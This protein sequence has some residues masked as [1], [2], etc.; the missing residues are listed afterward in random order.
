MSANWKSRK[1]RQINQ[2]KYSNLIPITND[3]TK[4]KSWTTSWTTVVCEGDQKHLPIRTTRTME[5]KKANEDQ[6]DDEDLVALFHQVSITKMM[7]HQSAITC[8]TTCANE[9]RET[10]PV[11]RFQIEKEF[12]LGHQTC[13]SSRLLSNQA[14]NNTNI[15][16]C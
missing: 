13:S 12:Q 5:Q 1:A 14:S 16:Q 11:M 3:W 6:N 7:H 15:R 4:H 2:V 10:N 8:A 9:E